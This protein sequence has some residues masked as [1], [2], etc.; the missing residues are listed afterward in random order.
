MGKHHKKHSSSS[1]SK[2]KHKHK[3]IKE[4][5]IKKEENVEIIKEK[6]C[7]EPSGI[8]AQYAAN[9]VGNGKVLKFTIPFDAKEPT[10]NWQIF[11][12]KKE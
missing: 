4:E 6:P 2:K 9:A 11:P 1:R 12:F 5:H 10:A 7:F 3:H 8:L